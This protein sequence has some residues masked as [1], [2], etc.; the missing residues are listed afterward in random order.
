MR[1]L[2]VIASMDPVNGGPCQGIRNSIPALEIFGVD[3]EVLCFDAP[4]SPFLEKD[5]FQIHLIGPAVGPYAY[6][7]KLRPWL[8]RN[9][10][11]FD[12]V[13]IH[14]LWLYNS[15]G[16]Y[17]VWQFLKRTNSKIP[18]LYIMPHG[19]LDPYF[20][21]SPGRKIKAIRN[22]LFWK[23]LEGKVVNGVDGVLFTCEEELLLARKTFHPYHPR[24][25][26]NIGYGI[27]LPPKNSL[28]NRRKFYQKCPEVK[29]KTFWLFLS[30][31]HPKKG[32]DNL[33]R[34]YVRLKE[35]ML[36]IPD[37]VIAGPGLETGYG[38]RL[39][40]LAKGN[41]V[42]F[43]GMVE[44]EAKWGAFY[45]CEAMILPSHQENFGIAVV[46]AMACGKPVLI[47][48]RV[49]I[50]REIQNANAGLVCG[51]T[52]EGIM[53]ML[54]YWSKETDNRKKEMGKNALEVFQRK[55]VVDQAAKKM[56]ACVQ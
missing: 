10:L 47:T 53:N 6:C 48:N 23:F 51:D 20:Q 7:S 4:D 1:V 46:E 30:R 26:I 31:I 13:I 37:L 54:I 50:W 38:K 55:F 35:E 56:L 21:R 16:T 40:E 32:V 2:R 27:Q 43:P 28:S 44:G 12:V 14:G 52:E 41:H 45:S 8:K 19:M 22:W 11:R 15:F 29:N 18:R 25:E 36:E 39:K 33:I 3:S 5:K 24:T 17:K 34:A 42:H 9:L 49:N